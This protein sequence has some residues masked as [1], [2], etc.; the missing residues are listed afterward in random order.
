MGAG[1]SILCLAY[2]LDCQHV[3]YQLLFHKSRH[4]LFEKGGLRW[5]VEERGGVT[6]DVVT[7]PC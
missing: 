5:P 3:H 4:G 2:G 6:A 7:C 1:T